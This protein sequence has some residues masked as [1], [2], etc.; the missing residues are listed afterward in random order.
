MGCRRLQPGVT[1]VLKIV[2][3]SKTSSFPW[4]MILD[5]VGKKGKKVQRVVGLE[6]EFSNLWAMQRSVSLGSFGHGQESGNSLAKAAHVTAHRME[7]GTKRC[8]RRQ[9]LLLTS[10]ANPTDLPMNSSCP[11]S[12]ETTSR[13]PLEDCVER[14]FPNGALEARERGKH[15]APETW[16]HNF[17]A[18]GRRL[19][20]S[21]PFLATSCD[22]RSSS[23]LDQKIVGTHPLPFRDR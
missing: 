16:S 8:K 2:R 3:S 12:S 10:S 7:Q 11:S 22:S 5:E 9:I 15:G 4:R 13:W 20:H 6:N 21:S 1:R 23:S 14:E 19:F 17:T 18:T